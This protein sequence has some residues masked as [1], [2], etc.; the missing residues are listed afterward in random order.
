[1]NQIEIEVFKQLEPDM[2]KSSKCMEILTEGKSVG[3]LVIGAV[4]EMRNTVVALT[5]IIDVAKP[6]NIINLS[7][8]VSGFAQGVE[9]LANADPSLLIEVFAAEE[10]A[11]A[12]AAAA[13][14]TPDPDQ[15]FA[16]REAMTARFKEIEARLAEIKNGRSAE[17][18]AERTVLK[19]ELGNMTAQLQ[20][21][22]ALPDQ[23]ASNSAEGPIENNSKE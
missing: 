5:T 11:A 6:I 10:K 14:K 3:I 4:G 16:D 20:A 7:E 22:D 23:E 15:K 19:E 18:N 8:G 1:M 17:T 9:A 21:W 13:G 12:E 2:I